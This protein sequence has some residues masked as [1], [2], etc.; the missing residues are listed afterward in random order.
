[1]KGELL[2]RVL[3]SV[4]DAIGVQNAVASAA[5][6]IVRVVGSAP[7][8]GSGGVDVPVDLKAAGPSPIV[9]GEASGLYDFKS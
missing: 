6:S 7:V 1:V 3:I 5:S 8:I 2:L 4:K 9:E